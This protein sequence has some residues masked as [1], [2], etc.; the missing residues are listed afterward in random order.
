MHQDVAG[1]KK[2][3]CDYEGFFFFNF[4]MELREWSMESWEK[5]CLV[6]AKFPP[7]TPQ[8]LKKKT[9]PIMF[10]HRKHFPSFFRFILLCEKY[11][12]DLQYSVEA[13]RLQVP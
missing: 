3:S 11:I 9:Y 4:K 7:I 2:K 1:W 8:K 5:G 13:K 6:S 12:S 10:R